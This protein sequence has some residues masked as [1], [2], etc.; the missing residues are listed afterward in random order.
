MG[1]PV[2]KQ[3]NTMDCGPTCLRMIAKYYGKHYKAETIRQYTGFNKQG[4]SM[5]G[6]SE[7]AERI[8]F[9]V[10]GV[11]IDLEQLPVVP[12][13][14]ILHWKQN[15]FVVLKNIR[16]NSFEIVDP[17]KGNIKL[18]KSE[19][20]KYWTASVSH[21]LKS[22]FALLL[23]P[24]KVFYEMKDEKEHKLSWNL[25]LKYLRT[26]KKNLIQLLFAITLGSL[27][28][29]IFPFLA[30]SIVDTGISQKNISFITIILVA[31]LIL[32]SS[33][34]VVNFIRTRL[35]LRISNFLN[36][37][38]LSDFWIKLTKLPISYFDQ[39]QTGDTLQRIGDH[40]R[41]QS[42][43]TGSVINTLFSVLT[44]SVYAI[45]LCTYNAWIFLIFITGSALYLF[46]IWFFLKIRRKINYKTFDLSSKENSATLQL[47]QGMQEIRLN[48]AERKKRWEWE[49]IQTQI[50]SLTTKSLSLNQFQ[51]AGATLISQFQNLY[52]SYFV[53]KLV[54]TN[55]LTLGSMVAIQFII[56]QLSGPISQWVEFVQ[57]GQDAR[58]S[59]ERLNEVH[60]LENEEHSPDNYLS[61]LP[62]DKSIHIF[63]L[64]FAYPG[65]GNDLILKN[66]NL[67]I[68]GGKTTAIVGA[69][70]SGK[71]TLLKILLK[72]YDNYSGDIIIGNCTNKGETKPS[73]LE[74]GYDFRRVRHSFWRMHC[75]VVLQDGFVF[76]DTIGN[77]IAVGK[78]EIDQNW[79]EESAKS[80]NIHAFIDSL[81]NK[82]QT[83]I[84]SSGLGLSQGQK[85][86]LL[87]ARAIY[88]Q[89]EYF[90]FDEATNALDA[91]N[92]KEIVE[93]LKK[94]FFGRTVVVVAHRLSTVR[95]ADHIIV[96]DNGQI[97]EK[98]NHQELVHLRGKYYELVKN[99]LD[100][101]QE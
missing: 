88:K 82:Y 65:A 98:G 91:N 50:F 74:S 49:V 54:V 59:M 6:I 30:Q 42:F 84:G 22:G 43:L 80:A 19:F 38:I 5:L 27:L 25:V 60:Q 55:E 100:L 72:I 13:P 93:H 7:T 23:E 35:L 86:R 44:F 90:L 31:Q 71:T 18:D 9:Q 4:V 14:C 67:N 89:P 28:Q 101:E 33:Q 45:V 66:I 37:Q 53:A 51:T 29:F 97:V 47:I 46:W 85:Q 26:S 40:S 99:Q 68:P 32:T 24:T 87:I 57:S 96:L 1:F 79:I 34:T 15:H 92:E 52:I 3:L 21:G 95:K 70:G 76:N 10:K 36:L 8:G 94:I 12:L 63:N 41:I 58:I 2:Y 20:L 16:S 61:T 11:N 73:D 83:Q 77:N 56:G 62:N 64:S 78:D 39:R 48:N 69:S 17:S 75:G 81:P